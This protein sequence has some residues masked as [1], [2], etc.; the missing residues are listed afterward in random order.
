MQLIVPFNTP[1]GT[2]NVDVQ[3]PVKEAYAGN[4]LGIN[5]ITIDV[6]THVFD[7]PANP[8]GA[9]VTVV[10]IPNVTTPPSSDG[11]GGVFDGPLE[12]SLDLTFE[13]G[14]ELKFTA[15]GQVQPT[16]T[17]GASCGP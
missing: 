10:A 3:Q 17:T 7:D 11:T 16:A 5:L 2:K 14:K 15:S 8:S 9:A 13:D 6:P 1:L 12:I 4:A